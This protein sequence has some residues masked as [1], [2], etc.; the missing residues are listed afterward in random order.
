VAVAAIRPSRRSLAV[1][2]GNPKHIRTSPVIDPAGGDEQEVRQP[3]DEANRCGIDG[4]VLLVRQ[5]D[6]QPLG[7]ACHGAGQMQISGRL[8]AARQDEGPQR[9]EIGVEGVDIGFD[10]VNL[11]VDDA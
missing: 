7:A 5:F 4:L 2:T 6:N 3:V 11:R 10:P 8:A 9:L 1:F